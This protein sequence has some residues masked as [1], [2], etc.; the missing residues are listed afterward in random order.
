MRRRPLRIGGQRWRV[1][2]V[3]RRDPRMQEPPDSTLDGHT[4]PGECLILLA[5]DLCADALEETLLHELD[6]A[7]NIV[8]GAKHEMDLR[9]RGAKLREEHEERIVRARTPIW[10]R[11]LKDLGFRF[12][13]GLLR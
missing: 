4:L 11:L 7:V 3:P 6:H 1:Q 10:H 5:D 2:L 13:K 9:C 8:S 12:P